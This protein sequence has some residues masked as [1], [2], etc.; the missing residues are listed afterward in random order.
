MPAEA[1][2]DLLEGLISRK[3]DHSRRCRSLPQFENQLRM[4]AL[5]YVK[6]FGQSKP[7]PC[8]KLQGEASNEMPASKHLLLA[9][10]FLVRSD[11]FFPFR[12]SGGW[13][14]PGRSVI[15][16]G[17]GFR[18]EWTDRNISIRIILNITSSINHDAAINLNILVSSFMMA[19]FQRRAY[20]Y[21]LRWIL[22]AVDS[23]SPEYH[24]LHAGQLFE[25]LAPFQQI[26]H[27]RRLI[28]MNL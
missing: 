16:I 1:S 17:G 28:F 2:Y 26:F 9:Q 25:S 3:L 5:G 8:F 4:N 19:K 27:Y 12:G 18:F 10:L 21:F 23:C 20:E 15:V 13:T 7:T 6:T 14:S 11:P 22:A 24:V